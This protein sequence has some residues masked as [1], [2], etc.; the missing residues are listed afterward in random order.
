MNWTGRRESSNI[1]DRRGLSRG[2]MAIGGG[3]GTLVLLVLA[4]LF[5]VDPSQLLQQTEPGASNGT[6]TRRSA[7]PGEEQLRHFTGVV[8]AD[9]EDVWNSLFREQL[10][11]AY[12]EPTLVL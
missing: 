8:L 1:E 2:G 5:G 3:I 10:H 9:T 11:K 12:R 4:L 7:D 6:E